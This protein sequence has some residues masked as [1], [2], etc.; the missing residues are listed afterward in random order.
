M[1]SKVRMCTHYYLYQ[2]AVPA[3]DSARSG[4]GLLS[5]KSSWDFGGKSGMEIGIFSDLSFFACGLS[6]KTLTNKTGIVVWSGSMD[7]DE[8]RTRSTDFRKENI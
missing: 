3:Q 8:E 7:D 4:L 1:Q 5:L 2:L 6:F